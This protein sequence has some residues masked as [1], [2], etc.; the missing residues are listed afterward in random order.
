MDLDT[1]LVEYMR[2]RAEL[3]KLIACAIS[4]QCFVLAV[5]FCAYGL[6]YNQFAMSKSV[7]AFRFSIIVGAV[8]FSI[9][10]AVFN[11]FVCMRYK[12]ICSSEPDYIAL[13]QSNDVVWEAYMIGRPILIFK[14]TISL[15]ITSLSG[16]IYIMLVVLTDRSEM[17]G[18]YG[19]IVVVI[20][21]GIAILIGLP[22]I[23]RIYTY[24]CV[25]REIHGFNGDNGNKYLIGIG[26][27][28]LTPLSI[29]GWYI[30]RF[31]TEKSEIAWI[32]FPMTAL[33]GLAIIYLISWIKQDNLEDS[34]EI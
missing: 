32:V 10:L 11:T 18:I 30:L 15:L 34:I 7:K 1:C 8:I 22:C 20:L 16:L 14:I 17:A 24:R 13:R 21:L 27:S 6:C 31:F 33:F 5:F 4:V 9:G 28:V 26:I 19:R 2:K 3:A 25:L 12:E 23:D 29:C